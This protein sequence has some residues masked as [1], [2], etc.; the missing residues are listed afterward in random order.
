MYISISIRYSKWDTLERWSDGDNT[1][2]QCFAEA[3]L[4]VKSID[5]IVNYT[6]LPS[7]FLLNHS[8]PWL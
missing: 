7:S 2:L 3:E 5:Y 8:P 1:L 6:Q 4:R